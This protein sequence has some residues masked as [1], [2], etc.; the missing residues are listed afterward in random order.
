MALVLRDLR[1]FDGTGR[2]VQDGLEIGVEADR[3]AWVGPQG[4]GP[5][6]DHESVSLGAATVLPGIVNGADYL[7][8]KA[9]GQ[10]YY[11]VYRQSGHYQLL[12]CVRS[13]L[14]LLSQ[15]VTTTVDIGAFERVTLMLRN[16][17]DMGLVTG[18]RI[19][20][21]GTPI[22]PWMAGEGVD[23]AS[24]TVEARDAGEMRDRADEL[25]AA[26][27]DYLCVKMEREDFKTKQI[28][29]FTLEEV[30]VAADV[31][32]AADKRLHVLAREVPDIP[33]ALEAGADS[34]SCGLNLWQVPEAA[35]EMA[36]R[37]VFYISSVASWPRGPRPIPDRDR[38]HRDS[39]RTALAAGVKV[40]PA[41][42]LYGV[43]PVDELIALIEVGLT[44][45][46]ALVAATRV[47]SEMLRLSD[48]IGTVEPGKRADLV[49]VDGDPSRDLTALHRVRFTVKDGAR[50]DPEAIRQVMGTSQTIT[51]PQRE[52]A[53]ARA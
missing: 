40:V 14:I 38:K 22:K 51:E 10:Y 27:V 39:L 49:A 17:I 43:N 23:I 7:S 11:D 35:A 46:Q 31:A 44:P 30:R 19:A 18:P 29:S 8:M 3:I 4:S 47:A 5:P 53:P 9:V 26:G 21:A 2:A 1:L 20:T 48:E 42:D 34:I 41:I 16:A 25:V 32:R 37:G 24:M 15:G 36:R 33:V 6:G 50:Y 45:T 52:A 28:R 13:G 12:R